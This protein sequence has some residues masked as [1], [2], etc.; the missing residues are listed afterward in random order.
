MIPVTENELVRHYQM[1]F[2]QPEQFRELIMSFKESLLKGSK[3]KTTI[4]FY[5][6]EKAKC[7]QDKGYLSLVEYIFGTNE[8]REPIDHILS[9]P[10]QLE[11]RHYLELKKKASGLNKTVKDYLLILVNTPKYAKGKKS[12]Y[13]ILNQYMNNDTGNRNRR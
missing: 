13:L 7:N 6:D 8:L 3:N 11:Y 12:L 2:L 9:L 5:E 1:H 10:K 4:Q